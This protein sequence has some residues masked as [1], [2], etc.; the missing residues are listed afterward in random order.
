M[1]SN[2]NAIVFSALRKLESQNEIGH[3]PKGADGFGRAGYGYAGSMN[4]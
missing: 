1:F 4:L 2:A 3:Q